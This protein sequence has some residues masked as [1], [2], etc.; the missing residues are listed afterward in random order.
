[1][2]RYDSYKDSG[3]EWIG[4]IPSDWECIRL[5]MLGDFSSSGID[6]KSNEDETPVRMVNYTD[7]IQSR[8]YYPIQTGEKEYMRV[9]TPQSK[10]EEHKLERGD[11]VFIPSSETHE[12]LGYSSLIDFDEEDIVYSYHILRY[13]T[14][15]PVYHYY[16]KYLINHHSVLNQ[17][18]SECKGT[19]RQIIGRDVFNNVRVVIPPISE[20]QQIVSFLDTKTSLID[21][22][23]EKTQRKIELLKEKRTSLIN[24]VVTKGL[25]PNVE[26]KDS[27]VEW[28]GDIPS[29]WDRVPLKYEIEILTDFTSNG[30]F[31]SL[32]ENVEYL[33][34]GFSRLVRLTDLRVN[35]ENDGIFI[36]EDSHNF[37]C[38]SEL[39]G[40]EI[41]ISCV[42]RY[43][44]FVTKMLF[45]K[46]KC[47]LGPNMYLIRNRIESSNVD[48]LIYL[49]N[50]DLIQSGLKN[51]I[52]K[53]TQEKINK[54]NVKDL[55][56]V[57][58][59]LSEQQQIVEYLDEQTQIIDNTIS[60]EEKR[61][62][63]LKEYR[64]SLIS[65]VVTGKKRVV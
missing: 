41:L 38:K 59:P 40:G 60:I 36:S 30:S 27:G 64:Q 61:I 1:M 25:N 18:S 45:N 31:K 56:I 11:M 52:N 58:P 48:Y 43:T 63:L 19:T 46:G 26:M 2:K 14:K 22:L 17:F 8:K 39:F 34:E 47:S 62:E 3:V 53:T 12:D 65:E 7:I 21:S 35:L 51:G 20:Q 23:I 32:R 29:H 9:T 28:I 50:S 55:Q 13:K 49:L 42:G 16:K 44:G 33:E 5:G 54:D 4:Q 10:F 6:K 15:K 37:L 24:E 57:R